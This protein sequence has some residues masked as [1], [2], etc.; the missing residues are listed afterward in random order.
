MRIALVAPIDETVPPRAYGGTELVLH[1]LAERLVAHGHDVMLLAAGGSRTRGRLVSIVDEPLR[2]AGPALKASVA[3]STVR[4]LCELEPEVIHNHTRHLL[5]FSTVLPAPMVTT[6]HHGFGLR[7]E[8]DAPFYEHAD[9]VYVS[10]SEDQPRHAPGLDFAATVHH[11]VPVEDFPFGERCDGY[12]AFVGRFAPE[13]G[14]HTAIDAALR[15]GLPLLLAAKVEPLEQAYF[16]AEIQ[17]RL[18]PG[19]IVYVGELG[20]GAKRRL[21]RDARALL[22]PVEWHEPFGL[23]LVEAMACGTPVVGYARGALPEIVRHGTTGFLADGPAEL[24]DGIRRA[25]LIDRRRCREHVARWFHA[26][27]MASAYERVYLPLTAARGTPRT[28]RT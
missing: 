9:A 7:P 15:A 24:L 28:V 27:R 25:H 10:V 5:A 23:V 18:V 4:L 17:P 16:D 1:F 8:E 12:L 14:A 22:S 20:Q 21:L 3:E 11:G 19:R 2:H 13:K 26:D 6:M